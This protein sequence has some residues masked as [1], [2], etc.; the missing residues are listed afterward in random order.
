MERMVRMTMIVQAVLYWKR[1]KITVLAT[2][3]NMIHHNLVNLQLRP[4]LPLCFLY[5]ILLFQ[6]QEFCHGG[7]PQPLQATRGI[8]AWVDWPHLY[9]CGIFSPIFRHFCTYYLL[10][11]LF[12]TMFHVNDPM[13]FQLIWPS[14]ISI[15]IL[16]PTWLS[17]CFL[18]FSIHSCITPSGDKMNC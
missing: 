15:F 8:T 5:L 16:T 9:H 13:S 12:F 11:I 17:F 18:Y 1:Q 3:Y 14:C 6:L 10:F 2:Q 7:P 4:Q